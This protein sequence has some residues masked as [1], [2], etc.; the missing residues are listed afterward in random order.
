MKPHNTLWLHVPAFILTR[1]VINTM[2]RMVYP[3]LPVFARGL[4]VDVTAMGLALSLRSA[5]G[6]VGPFLAAVSDL[7]GRKA[8]LVGGMA[9]LTAGATLAAVWPTFLAFVGM[10]ILSIMG[11]LVFVPSVQA[12]IGDRVT[13]RRRGLVIAMTEYS[14]SISFIVGVPAV[15]FLIARY[16]WQAPFPWLAG[17]GLAGMVG[18]WLLL[19]DD[20]PPVGGASTYWSGFGQ[21]L[22]QPAAR[23]GIVLAMGMSGANEL[24]NLIFG[25]WLED[26]FAVKIGALAAASVVIGLSELGGEGLVSLFTDRWGKRRAV[27]AGLALNAGAVLALPGLGGSLNAAFVGLFLFYITFEFTMVSSLPLMTEVLPGARAT[28]MAMFV[29][30]AAL[31]RALSS[32]VALRLYTWA[33]PWDAVSPVLLPVLAAA[34]LNGIALLALRLIPENSV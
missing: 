3:L 28:F 22:R 31:G 25:V 26:T 21:V 27:A 7:R 19:P 11:N 23:A 34:S 29:A 2:Q 6:L 13:Y 17:L 8:G 15:S 5:T 1:S 24:V 16:G 14:W 33:G 10:L 32:L 9:M 20:R 30:G 12:Y 18:L 4:G